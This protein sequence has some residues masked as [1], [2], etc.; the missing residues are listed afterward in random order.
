MIVCVVLT[1]IP[2]RAVPMSISAPDVSAQKPPTGFSRVMP[3]PIVL[4]IRQPP[5][6]VPSPIAACADSTTQKGT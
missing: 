3:M 4:T 2:P 1:G 6:S 5:A